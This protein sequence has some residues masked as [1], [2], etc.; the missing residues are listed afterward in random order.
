VSVGLPIRSTFCSAQALAGYRISGHNLLLTGLLCFLD[1][2]RLI[3]HAGL[4]P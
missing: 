1:T 2:A 4:H 3:C